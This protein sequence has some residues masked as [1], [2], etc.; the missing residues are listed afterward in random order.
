[1]DNDQIIGAVSE[2]ERHG[3]N[4]ERDEMIL[5]L[6]LYFQLKFGQLNHT[7]QQVR[8]M[9]KL[10]QRTDNS[11]AYRLTNYA[12]CDPYII[13][14]GRHGND[15]GKKICQPIWN[16]FANDK[17]KLYRV[18]S[19]IRAKLENKNIEE[20]LPVDI[21]NEIKDY[22]GETR[23]AVVK[24]RINQDVFRKMILNNYDT[25]CA[26]TG[27][28]DKRLLVASHIVPWAHREDT[29]LDPENGICLSALYDKAFDKGLIT[30][31]PKDYTVMLSPI[32]KNE[33]TENVYNDHFKII[34]NK[35]I[36][37]PEEHVPNK[38]FLQYHTEKVFLQ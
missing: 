16:E 6:S 1:M 28:N 24:V 35:P 3:L 12:S 33:L 25:K 19:Q 26:I 20:Q 13:A 37:L 18:A 8:K 21:L 29:R 4:W 10:I 17:E 11:V 30:I 32:L 14:S 9:A 22:K 15:G 31:R 2:G 27:I 7:N 5:V 34:E 23:D 36:M 38:E